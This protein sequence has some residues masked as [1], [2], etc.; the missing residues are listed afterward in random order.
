MKGLNLVILI[1][2]L[3]LS[4]NNDVEKEIETENFEL[5]KLDEGVY[6]CVHKFGGNAIC[7]SGIV[8]NGKETIIFDSFLSPEAAKE[9]IEVTKEL[10]LSPI[11]Y[12]INSHG[13]NDHIRGNQS[14]DSDVTIIATKKTSEKIEKEEPGSIMAEKGYAKSQFEHLENEMKKYKGDTT[15]KDYIVMK[16]MKPYF[17]ELSQSHEKIKTRLP[18]SFVEKRKEIEGK[19]RNVVLIELDS[20]HTVSDLVMYLPNEKILFTGDIVFNEFHPFL[21]DGNSTHLKSGLGKLRE[22]EIAKIIPGHGNIGGKELLSIMINYVEDLETI[23]KQAVEKKENLEDLKKAGMP[24]KYQD[25]W[26]GNFYP[27]NLEYLYKMELDE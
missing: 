14:F 10:E 8:D 11:K 20:C 19:T 3:L 26:L 5:I 18:S 23:V 7:N 21:G 12:V 24:N 6:G 4:C 25:W 2:G 9:L 27:M 16:M 1:I 17:E 15:A 22:M 13:H